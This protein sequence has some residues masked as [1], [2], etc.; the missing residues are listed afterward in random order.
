MGKWL[1][2]W[3]LALVATG[4]L[5][6]TLRGPWAAV[7]GAVA[8]GLVLGLIDRWV[9]IHPRCWKGDSWRLSIRGLFK[10]L[11][12]VATIWCGITVAGL[13]HAW[14]H[15]QSLHLSQWQSV[16]ALLIGYVV[17]QVCD[18]LPGGHFTD[19]LPT[20]HGQ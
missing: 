8:G 16:G 5:F 19:R 7:P 18:Y 11:A 20:C 14:L 3:M 2:L 6:F 10:D 4:G 9:A 17:N 1:F 15:G 12:L 13:A